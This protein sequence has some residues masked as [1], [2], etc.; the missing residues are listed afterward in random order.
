[1]NILSRLTFLLFISFVIFNFT[2]CLST[3]YKEYNFEINPDGSGSGSITFYNIVSIEDK[4]K[5]V[6]YKDFGELVSDYLEGTRFED[7]NAGYKVT[8][9]ELIKQDSILIG[10]IEFTFNNL[11]DVKFY[12]D[13]QCDCS[14]IMYYM[15]GFGETYSESN[16]K[17]L[18]ENRDFPLITW[19]SGTKNLY[20]KTIV[21]D[22]LSNAH[23]LAGLYDDWKAKQK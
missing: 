6:S 18:G 22:D 4:E 16:G 1:M 8:H 2:G 12:K 15:G 7:D 11:A 14:P 10:K 17:Y 13:E 3:E 5:D 21:Q 23:S 19:K 20:I 9:K